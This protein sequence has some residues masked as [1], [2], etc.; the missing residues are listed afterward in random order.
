MGIAIDELT[1]DVE[2]EVKR[3]VVLARRLEAVSQH[4]ERLDRVI[5]TRQAEIQRIATLLVVSPT[6]TKCTCAI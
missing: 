4:R 1:V 6:L 3:E 5:E 2:E